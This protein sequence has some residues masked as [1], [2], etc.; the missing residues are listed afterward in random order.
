MALKAHSIFYYGH[1]IDENNNLIDFADS[2]GGPEKTAEI[3][4]GSYTLTKFLEVITAALNA[5]SSLDWTYTLD[6]TTRIVTLLSSGPADLLLGTGT[7]FLNT[8]ATLL[9]FPQAD[10]LNDDT[11]VG[12]TASGSEWSPQFPLQDYKPKDKNKKLVNAV[13]SK[14]AS[15]DNVSV[16]SFGTDRFIKM[17]AKYITNQP[18]EGV[19]RNNP[20]AVAEVEAFLDYIV[21]KN[22]VEFMEDEDDRDVFEKVYLE[23]TPQNADG[24]QY[25]LVEYV[26]RNLPEYFETGLLTFKVINKE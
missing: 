2:P 20:N 21:E 25:D 23:S 13:V 11:F 15:G 7:N 1:K 3:P 14:S 26:D 8:P 17:N 4:V 12:S 10:I 6:R 16:Q 24:T 22:P 5:A 19:L 18:T 9:G